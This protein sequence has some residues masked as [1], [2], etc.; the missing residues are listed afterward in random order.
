ME[1]LVPAPTRAALAAAGVDWAH[2]GAEVAAMPA[3]ALLPPT[4]TATTHGDISHGRWSH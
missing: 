2:L 4:P 3:S 1:S